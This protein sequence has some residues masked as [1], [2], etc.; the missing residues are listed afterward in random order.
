[1]EGEK[2]CRLN[3]KKTWRAKKGDE[4]EKLISWD[5]FMENEVSKK[6]KNCRI[7]RDLNERGM[8]E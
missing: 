2:F 4:L 6:N 1:V 7:R 3:F 8:N 5:S